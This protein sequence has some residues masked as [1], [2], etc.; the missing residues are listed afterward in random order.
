M[1]TSSRRQ[2]NAAILFAI[3]VAGTAAL[4]ISKPDSTSQNAVSASEQIPAIT[5]TAKR[6]TASEKA[7]WSEQDRQDAKARHG[8]D[9]EEQDIQ[10]A[11]FDRNRGK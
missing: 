8:D 2:I 7:A 5:I 9:E 1:K 6:L 10:N 4:V 3:L 11:L